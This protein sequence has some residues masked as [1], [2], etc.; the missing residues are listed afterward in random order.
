MGQSG[1]AKTETEKPSPL[2]DSSRV[3]D[4][5]LWS[6]RADVLS[7]LQISSLRTPAPGTLHRLHGST[8]LRLVVSRCHAD[9]PLRRARC[10]PR[11]AQTRANRASLF[12][13]TA[14]SWSV[15]AAPA[16]AVRCA[17]SAA[18]GRCSCISTC[19]A[20]VWRRRTGSRIVPAAARARLEDHSS[21]PPP[22]STL[23]APALRAPPPRRRRAGVP[24]QAA[25]GHPR[26]LATLCAPPSPGRRRCVARQPPSKRR[27]SSTGP[28]PCKTCTLHTIP[29]GAG[30]SLRSPAGGAQH[31]QWAPGVDPGT[32]H[33]PEC[34]LR[35]L[36]LI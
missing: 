12:W 30:P 13:A 5:P 32:C 26:S 1:R 27:S 4:G 8:P 24:V 22:P 28:R 10:A 16:P 25:L 33:A 6:F 19:P 15:S 17:A 20:A 14:E 35:V 7:L 18:A 23:P 21:T 9:G 34:T 31:T 36:W 29:R 11:A 2:D 3:V